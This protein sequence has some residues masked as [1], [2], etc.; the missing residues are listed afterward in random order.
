MRERHWDQLSEQMC[1][2]FHPDKSFNLTKA[3]GM[4]LMAHLEL[5]TRVSDVAGT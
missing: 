4:G 3:E 1:S 5:I 2:S